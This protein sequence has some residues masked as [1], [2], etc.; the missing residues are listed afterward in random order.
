MYEDNTLETDAQLTLRLVKDV[1][2]DWI[3]IRPELNPKEYNAA[4]KTPKRTTL[5]LER[6]K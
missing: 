3:V 2:R 4:N 5:T 1:L 6:Y